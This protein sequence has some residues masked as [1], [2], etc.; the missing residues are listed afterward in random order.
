ML[1]RPWAGRIEM[2][3]SEEIGMRNRK[4]NRIMGV[5]LLF[6]GSMSLVR[7]L[8]NPRLAALHGSDIV[9][10]TGCGACL[11][12]ALLALLGRVYFRSD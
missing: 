10:L 4:V 7:T 1:S 5:V 3:R 9:A 12:V 2:S 6:F 11:G 8:N